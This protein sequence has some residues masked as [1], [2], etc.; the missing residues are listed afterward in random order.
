MATTVDSD[1]AVER[2]FAP[3]PQSADRDRL[4]LRPRPS[5]PA[6][7]GLGPGL[8]LRLCTRVHSSACR[9][10]CVRKDT[11]TPSPVGVD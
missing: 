10:L 3:P 7:I 4:R 8:Q 6:G 5:A 1:W 2:A 11:E 9:I